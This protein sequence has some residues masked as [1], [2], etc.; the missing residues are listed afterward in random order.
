MFRDETKTAPHHRR[1]EAC[2][3]SEHQLGLEVRLGRHLLVI[4]A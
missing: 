3:K 1:G 4:G 2:Q